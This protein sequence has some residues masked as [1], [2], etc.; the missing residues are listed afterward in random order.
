MKLTRIFSHRAV[1]RDDLVKLTAPFLMKD[2][3]RFTPNLQG[4]VWDEAAEIVRIGF[5][6]EKDKS[7]SMKALH[8]SLRAV[9]ETLRQTPANDNTV[10]VRKMDLRVLIDSAVN[11]EE[12]A[13]N[14]HI[15]NKQPRTPS[16]RLIP[17]GNGAYT[18][19]LDFSQCIAIY[20]RPNDDHGCMANKLVA[21][22]ENLQDF[23]KK[24]PLKPLSQSDVR[25]YV[26]RMTP[27]Y[28]PA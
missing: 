7:N 18:S 21:F 8:L 14:L 27:I 9:G 12:A 28:S 25:A 22:R 10:M 11:L 2:I 19:S 17:K 15:M 23:S 1:A 20:N 6:Y 5:D 13:R 4:D 3:A 26:A 24:H 16:I